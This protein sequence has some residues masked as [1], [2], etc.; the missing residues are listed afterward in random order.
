MRILE[1]VGRQLAAS[2]SNPGLVLGRSALVKPQIDG[3]HYSK[4]AR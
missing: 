1:D 3:C 2:T 4:L